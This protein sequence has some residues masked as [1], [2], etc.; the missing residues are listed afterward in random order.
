MIPKKKKS[1]EYKKELNDKYPKIKYSTDYLNGRVQEKNLAKIDKYKEAEKLRVI[2]EKLKE[3]ENEN[4]EKEKAAKIN[5]N[6]EALETKQNQDLKTLRDKQKRSYDI[7]LSR[8]EKDFA[9]LESKYKGKN[10]NLES[11]EKMQQSSNVK[12]YEEE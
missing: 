7:L 9:T 3:K 6:M 12:T 2:N 8:K 5:R 1:E 10:Q 4:Y 11:K